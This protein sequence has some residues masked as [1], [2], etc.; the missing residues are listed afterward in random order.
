[1][2][3]SLEE[4]RKQYDALKRAAAY[5]DGNM[6]AA[7][8]FVKKADRLI[9][10][11][12]GS[13]YTIAESLART[14]LFM[15]EKPTIAAPAGEILLYA[16]K[17]ARLFEG[18]CLIM[19]TRSGST[20]ELMRA[21]AAVREYTDDFSIVSFICA[22]D[23]E[24]EQISDA[25]FVMPWCFDEAVC[26]TRCVSSL[27]FS[28]VYFI[29]EYAGRE[30]VQKDL[31]KVIDGGEAYLA[32]IEPELRELSGASW[33]N[34]ITLADAEI[35]GICEEGALAFKEISQLPS[36]YYHMLDFRHGP[37]VMA[38]PDTLIIAAMSDSQSG[39]ERDLIADCIKKGGRIV[40]YSDTPAEIDGITLN[41]VYG[42][43]LCH[44]ARGLAFILICQLLAC[45][46]AEKL[47]VDGDPEGLDAWI[48]L[49]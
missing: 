19:S 31:L 10:T 24:A 21:I 37:I 26:Q 14:A 35:S 44:V 27:Y 48:E 7:I 29:A 3:N 30:D 16:K 49:K 45:F 38:H 6:A 8:S 33:T 13:G 23:T 5:L 22:E 20:S 12:C 47:G 28:G 42:E 46:K 43:P 11:G 39:L 15:Q 18:A 1:M 17:Y 25:A 36:N 4:A 32:R 34:V 2:A 41:I 9:F 40:V